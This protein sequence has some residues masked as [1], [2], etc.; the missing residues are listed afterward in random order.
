M[1]WGSSG[2]AVLAAL[3]ASFN[4]IV[5]DGEVRDGPAVADEA[6]REVLTVGYVGPD[7]DASAESSNVPGGLGGQRDEEEYDI[8]CAVALLSGDE[9]VPGTRARVFE[10]LAE[11]GRRLASDPRLGG[12]CM[13]ARISA[14]SLREDMTDGGAWARIRFDVRVRAFTTP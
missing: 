3:V 13:R 9:D 8:H 1:S 6:A 5:L 7:D 11:C 12:T 10:L 4:T 14:W 2:P